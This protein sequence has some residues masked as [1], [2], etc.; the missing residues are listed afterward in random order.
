M[1][2]K[3]V[4]IDVFNAKREKLCNLYDSSINAKGQAHSIVYRK[5]IGGLK[6]LSFTLPRIE[7]NKRNYRWG[8]IR[9]EYLVRLAYGRTKDW[10][11]LHAPT[12]EHSKSSINQSIE[13]NHISINLKT[14]NLYLTFDDDNGI[15][16]IRYLLEQVLKG[17]GWTLGSCD[18]FYEKDG[19]TEKIRSYSSDG[20]VGAYQLI[21]DICT[22]F[23]A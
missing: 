2:Q 21:S 1:S 22:L 3:H 11:I 6:S 9:N 7:D 14:K 4:S 15:G 13:C 23:N 19:V 8:F 5:E 16:T 20:K 18:T 10:F 17:T 12:R